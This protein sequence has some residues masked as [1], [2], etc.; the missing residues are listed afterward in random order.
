MASLGKQI[1]DF[2]NG[3]TTNDNDEGLRGLFI[4]ELKGIYYA[5]RSILD[6]LPA[7]A[8]AATTDQVRNAFQQH[9]EETRNQV[10]RLERIFES[11]GVEADDKT[12]NAIDGL[13]D[14]GD[15]V[16][17]ST[18]DGSLTRD[19][20]LIIAAQKIEHHEIAVYGSLHTL[21]RLLGFTEAVQLLEETLQEEKN[22]DRKLT[23]IAESFVNERAKSED[24]DVSEYG[25]SHTS[26]DTNNWSD[27]KGWNKDSDTMTADS[28]RH[29]SGM[30]YG[31]S[32]EPSI[33]TGQGRTSDVTAGGPLGV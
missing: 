33:S 28:T 25:Q 31:G 27:N 7:M 10:T 11:I 22:T 18:D 15:E 9:L 1:S 23:Q 8:D 6:N 29:E 12:C 16:I 2:F 19:A 13:A 24:R 14:D 21:A 5:E 30:N 26:Q 4:D 20:G 17:S 3:N 32:T